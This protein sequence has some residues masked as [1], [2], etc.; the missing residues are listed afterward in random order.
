[1]DSA[2]AVAAAMTLENRCDEIAVLQ[3]NSQGRFD[4]TI[5]Y[6]CG[7]DQPD[8]YFWVEY[9]IGGTWTTVYDPPIACNTYWDYA[10]GTEVTLRLTDPRV[11][12]CGGDVNLAG[13]QVA[14]LAIGDGVSVHEIQP[15]AAGAAEGLTTAG[16]PFGGSL[17]PHVWFGRTALIAAGI[18][19]YRWSYR[20]LTASDGV[21]G[22]SD[23][24]HTLGRQVIRHYAVID[25]TPPDF[26][27]SFPPYPLGPDPVFPGQD[28]FQIQPVNPP[29]GGDGWAPIDAHEDSASAFF[30]THLLAGGADLRSIQELLGHASLSTTQRYTR[31]DAGQLRVVWDRA[32]PRG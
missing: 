32:H 21:T 11:A 5:W 23:G 3:T 8:L 30:L 12:P 13:L 29:P 2:I 1:M 31:V 7:G 6:L 26:K 16:E 27:L 20:H 24:W 9:N 17:E 15:A 22:V 28:L 25:L 10:C 19:H 18:T 14:I 4:T